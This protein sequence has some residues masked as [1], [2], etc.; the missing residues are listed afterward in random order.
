MAKEMTGKPRSEPGRHV[1]WGPVRA[2]RT[3]HYF[4]GGNADWSA[5]YAD[6][7]TAENQRRW[8][9]K[10]IEVEVMEAD[11]QQDSVAVKVQVRTPLIG[12]AFPSMETVMRFAWVEVQAMDE[13]GVTLARTRRRHGGNFAKDRMFKELTS[14]NPEPPSPLIYRSPR[15]PEDGSE[16]TLI[17]ADGKRDFSLRLPIP[18][19]KGKVAKLAAQVYNSWDS[20]P[21]ARTEVP[22]PTGSKQNL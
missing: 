11:V 12:H 13:G 18:I 5:K 2:R 19:G 14:D 16:N 3:T 6:E 10:S 9:R 22:V 7:A 8:N 1:T 17:S 21:V 20:V 15:W 4:T